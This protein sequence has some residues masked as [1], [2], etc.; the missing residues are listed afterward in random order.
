MVKNSIPMNASSRNSHDENDQNTLLYQDT[1]LLVELLQLSHEYFK[2]RSVISE[3]A[4]IA[5][6]A[7]FIEWME[8]NCPENAIRP[9]D[10][11]IN[12]LE[13]HRHM[14]ENRWKHVPTLEPFFA[15]MAYFIQ[16]GVESF[17]IQHYPQSYELFVHQ[18]ETL[19]NNEPIIQAG[20]ER[21]AYLLLEQLRQKPL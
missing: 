10:Y 5:F 15:A 6:L 7:G 21:E 13:F 17:R 19:F 1:A 18:L 11:H 9:V 20:K 4:F 2:R 12:A 14:Y 8:E 16:Y 3:E